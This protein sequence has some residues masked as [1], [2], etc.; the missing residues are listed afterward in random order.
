MIN[1]IKKNIVLLKGKKIK[2]YV[3]V[4][5]N[6]NEMYEGIVLNTYQNIW[7]LK[8]NTDVKSFGYKDILINTVVISS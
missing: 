3:D 7:T 5:R 2:V 1:E 6:K 4:G 8:T